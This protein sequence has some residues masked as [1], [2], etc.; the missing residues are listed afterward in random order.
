M[1]LFNFFKKSNKKQS[2][3]QS[4]ND[5]LF[6]PE[7]NKKR[8]DAAVEFL[9][10]FQDKTPLLNGRPH[11]GTVLSIGARLAG[12]SLYRSINKQDFEPGMVILSE[13]VNETYPKLLNMFAH[14][15]K[16]YGIDVM[17]KPLVQEIPEQDKPLM[18]LVQVQ[19]NYQDEYNEIMKKHGLD[20][21]V[22][23]QAGMIVCSV[24]FNYHCVSNKDLDPYVATGIVAMGVVEGAKT[25][26]IPL[27]GKV[28]SD[29]NSK[30]HQAAGLIK[31]I[32]ESSVSGAG[33]R[34]VL[35]ETF[36]AGKEAQTNGGKY[37]LVHPEVQEQLKTA[38]FDLFLIYETALMIELQN[39]IEQ[40]DFV[41]VNVDELLQE[42]SGKPNDQAPMHVRQM[43]WLKENA[44]KFGYEQSGN[45]WKLKP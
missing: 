42:W 17:A 10:L 21:L 39:N 19:E 29:N 4:D 3:T 45:S 5:N 37:I 32:A 18:D 15:C 7:Q 28:A 22:S 41:D 44:E 30:E 13:E 24:L 35:G 36:A 34:L 6:S 27:G 9:K 23:A 31:T 33:T 2:G 16:Q 40:V 43:L 38:N 14:F 11:A 1:P 26:P 25:S 12:T 20:H 8:Y